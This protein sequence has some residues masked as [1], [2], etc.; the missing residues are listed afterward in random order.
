MHAE[1]D[2][3]AYWETHFEKLQQAASE[4]GNY[5]F[6]TVLG[7]FRFTFFLGPLSCVFLQCVSWI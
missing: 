7:K 5:L 3:V 1:T 6:K 4:R 2:S